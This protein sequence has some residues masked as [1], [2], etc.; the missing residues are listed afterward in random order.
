MEDKLL[1]YTLRVDRAFFQ[2]FRYIAESEGRSANKE[3]EQYIKK[4]VSEFES[5]HGKIEVGD[6]K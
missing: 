6:E 4:R 3:I 1:R 2:K 5:I